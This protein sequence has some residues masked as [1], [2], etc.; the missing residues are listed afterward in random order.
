MERRVFDPRQASMNFEDPEGYFD[1][2][3]A[4]G[5]FL[6]FS[7]LGVPGAFCFFLFSFKG[8]VFQSSPDASN[9]DF[10]QYL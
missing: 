7:V 2:E 9:A 3:G 8:V 10:C 5:S 4:R 1:L 6:F